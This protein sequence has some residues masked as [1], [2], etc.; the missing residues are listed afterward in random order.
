MKKKGVIFDVDGTLLDTMPIWTDSGARYLASIGIEAEENLGEKLFAM[1]VDG[2]AVYLKE[3]YHL[4]MS[5]EEIKRGILSM[6]EK[7]Y[8]ESADFKAGARELLEY[9]KKKNVSMSIATSTD[10]YCILAAFD[11]LG[12]TDYFDVILSCGELNT[13]KSEPEIFFEAIKAMGTEV[14]NT[15]IFEDGLYSIKTGKKAGFN[16]V[17]VYDEVSEKDQQEIEKYA[18]IYVKD[19]RELNLV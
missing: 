4:E 3:N 18:D 14:A 2:G 5:V 8:F 13:T 1:T 10:R 9:L 6:V 17:G 19:L 7:A 15:W 12:Y 11:R 16:V